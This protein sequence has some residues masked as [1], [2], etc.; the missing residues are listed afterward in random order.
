MTQSSNAPLLSIVVPFNNVQNYL[1]QCLESLAAQSIR[2]IEVI[3]VDDGST[4]SSGR[5][6]AEMAAAD[7]RFSTLHIQQ[8]GPGRARNAGL[9][10]VTGQYLAFVDGDDEVTPDGFAKLIQS[11]AG[12][13]SDIAS[14]QVV[15]MTSTR[16]YPSALHARALPT[17]KTRTHISRDATLLYDVTMWNKV[18]RRDFWQHHNFRF[19]EG[20]LYEDIAL[21]T[22]T[23]IRA[24]AVDVLT[25]TVYRWRERDD[26]SL[27]ITQ[28]RSELS[29]LRDRVAALK[30]ISEFLSMNGPAS[31]RDPLDLKALGTD[32]ALHIPALAESNDDYVRGFMDLVGRYLRT[33]SPAVLGKLKPALQL[34]YQLV[35]AGEAAALIELLRFER[36]NKTIPVRRRGRHMVMTVPPSTAA[37]VPV[38]ALDMS[39][40]LSI[41]SGVEEIRWGSGDLIIAGY[42]YIESVPMQ[43]PVVAARRLVLKESGTS[44]R[45][46]T[47]LRPARRP[48]RTAAAGAPNLGYDWCGFRA[49]IDAR[50]LAPAAGS[51]T[52]TWDVIVQI[53]TPVAAHGQKLGPARS[54]AAWIPPIGQHGDLTV[55]PHWHSG[56]NLRLTASTGRALLTSANFDD[57]QLRLTIS[58]P[59]ADMQ[60][61]STVRIAIDD[62]DISA[63][64]TPIGVLG[65]RTTVTATFPV[66]EFPALA[67]S[68]RELPL[69]L[70]GAVGPRR[71]VPTFPGEVSTT[72]GD[73]EILIRRA[74]DGDVRVVVRQPWVVAL[75]AQWSGAH[76]TVHGRVALP[77]GD[78][79]HI[80]LRGPNGARLDGETWRSGDAF[81]TRF[82]LLAVPS[83]TGAGPIG[84]GRWALLRGDP[85]APDGAVRVPAATGAAA[86]I[87]S[88]RGEGTLH[89]DTWV[90]RNRTVAITV[91]AL[92]LAERG[93]F[94]QHRLRSGLYARSRRQPIA[95]L[96][97]FESWQGKQYSDNPRAISE[98]LQR[99]GD[100]RRRVWI[101]RDRSVPVPPGV[102]TVVRGSAEYY[103]ALGTARWLV[104]NDSTTPHMVKRPEQ[105]YLQTWHGTPFKKI[106]FDIAAIHFRNKSYLDELP[107][108]VS[109]W[110][111]L[112]SPDPLST[113]I[114]R[115]AFHFTGTMLETG[116]PRNDVLVAS[117]AAAIRA[118]VRES[119]GI[120]ASARVVLWAPT[121][122]DHQYDNAGRYTIAMNDDIRRLAASM[123][124]TGVLLFRG[125]HLVSGSIENASVRALVRNVSDY[126]DIAELYLASDALITDYSSAMFDYAVLGRPILLYA[127]DLNEYRDHIRG[128][129]VDFE[130]T[131]PGP[132]MT[133]VDDVI[134]ALA[135]LPA[136]AAAHRTR[137]E[138]FVGR[139]CSL[140]DGKASARVVDRLFGPAG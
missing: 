58:A 115:N 2:D 13:R 120:D 72:V 108:E 16:S 63:E 48:Q 45:I 107:A 61:E 94:R 74:G 122:R 139:Y 32:L 31:L 39:R 82:R 116:Y 104:A 54:G 66:N 128:F 118:R 41:E 110:N 101:V 91:H 90:D 111:S 38:S 42:A 78:L 84:P 125:H 64:I 77:A 131:A 53:L 3:L 76:F 135:D 17:A 113:E 119:L 89:L 126:P 109:K 24:L 86:A 27:S 134:E 34:K 103:R 93:G 96:V 79:P 25:S 112:L 30:T 36:E 98:E 124:G 26:G 97:L 117:D 70:V 19:P 21:A 129:Y 40:R 68:H 80:F 8:S 37:I 47:W 133:G 106:G 22:E 75:S 6:A 59:T 11:L 56:R 51:A 85:D 114:L 4:D 102:D 137:Y 65:N 132:V 81:R 123:D 71:I 95:D 20:V 29:N 43:S 9:A 46:V 130:Q 50:K 60:P 87:E 92:P 83:I 14:G 140:S 1:P 67:E 18:F 28:R 49:Q 138:L 57:D 12:S 23:H 100:S 5:I 15:R 73:R 7:P 99:R 127:W 69:Y 35:K 52:T 44:R 136:F 10:V 88:A 33:C 55:V 105:I 62:G 121:W